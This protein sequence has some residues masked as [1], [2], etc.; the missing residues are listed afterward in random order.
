MK[1]TSP[2]R[3]AIVL[4]ALLVAAIAQPAAIGQEAE[5]NAEAAIG[6]EAEAVG[7]SQPE[8]I[9]DAANRTVAK[10]NA[11]SDATQQAAFDEIPWDFRPYR[12]LI[13]IA[14][15]KPSVNANSLRRSLRADLDRDFFTIWRMQVADAPSFVRTAAQRDL[16]SMT[17]GSLTAGDPVIAVKRDH[18]DAIRIRFAA[19]VGQH[20]GSVQG[21][22][23]MINDVRSRGEAIGRADLAGVAAKLDEFKGDSL[24]LSEQWTQSSTEALLMRRG[25]AAMLTEP[26]AKIIEPPIAGLVGD[27]TEQ[28]DKIFVV[29]IATGDPPTSVS[30]VEV[31]TRMQYFGRPVS[32]IA[33]TDFELP[34][35]ISRAV[36]QAFTPLIRIDEAGSKSATG[37]VRAHGLINQPDSPGLIQQD[38]VLMP[39]LRKDDRNG[40]PMAIGPLDWAYLYVT[41]VDG[42]RV[43]ADI[44]A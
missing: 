2:H 6:Q 13:W 5:A 26:E 28:F 12:V 25:M 23:S 10:L 15:D 21:L 27:F 11:K 20:V 40:R 24:A 18:P 43:K 3:S 39:M 29:R 38:D 22:A 35:A 36:T 16:S 8:T 9:G 32:T 37:L 7:S 41:E 42:K 17:Y 1:L 14:S 44:H 30:V 31:E 34:R 33:A 19:D 4:F